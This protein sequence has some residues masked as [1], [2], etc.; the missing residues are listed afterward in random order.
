M[1]SMLMQHVSY[2]GCSAS[3]SHSWTAARGRQTVAVRATVAYSQQ[4]VTRS[5]TLTLAPRKSASHFYGNTASFKAYNVS[6]KSPV[7]ST[8]TCSTG[9]S[10]TVAVTGTE[11][12]SATETTVPQTK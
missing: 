11:H 4:H 3:H 7:S 10:K 8:I 1:A 9:D 5:A 6:R 2:N 12:G